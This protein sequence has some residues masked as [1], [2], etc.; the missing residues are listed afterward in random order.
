MQKE[1]RKGEKR[2]RG[3]DAPRSTKWEGGVGTKGAHRGRRR[4]AQPQGFAGPT[5][6]RIGPT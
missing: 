5:G 2:R 6:D 1:H 4:V 3:A